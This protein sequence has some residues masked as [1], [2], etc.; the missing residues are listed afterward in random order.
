IPSAASISNNCSDDIQ[1]LISEWEAEDLKESDKL[2]NEL[3]SAQLG[4]QIKPNR[5]CEHGGP[6]CCPNKDKGDKSPWE[7]VAPEIA[8][9]KLYAVW[10]EIYARR[11]TRLDKLINRCK[12]NDTEKQYY[13]KMHEYEDA[14]SQGDFVSA[15]NKLTEASRYV[16]DNVRNSY[17]SE[18]S[19]YNQRVEQHRKEEEAEKKEKEEYEKR[20][21]EEAEKKEKEESEKR[22]KEEKEKNQKKDSTKK[23]K[24]SG[25]TYVIPSTAE[26][27]RERAKYNNIQE[28][29]TT[30]ALRKKT[31]M[32]M[33]LANNAN[34]EPGFYEDY[35]VAYEC[36]PVICFNILPMYTNTTFG[37]LVTNS[38]YGEYSSISCAF[39]MG[40]GANLILW[41]VRG[42][43]FG[44][45]GL[46]NYSYGS[47]FI[48]GSSGHASNFLYGTRIMGGL[49]KYKVVFDLGKGSRSG[50]YNLDLDASL[51]SSG[52]LIDPTNNYTS[53]KFDYSL[54]KSGYG[55]MYESY[56]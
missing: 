25:S 16:T 10:N 8:L 34:R 55:L 48:S 32:V 17:N 19:N 5:D 27:A 24:S 47:N 45:G 22:K 23:S 13:Q 52:Y 1:N 40:L 14:M 53:G 29:K 7:K 6:E 43:Y 35:C 54:K 3:C 30:D 31:D 36:T 12:E 41:P 18:K 46:C 39:G 11:K 2:R 42:P 4:W 15:K 49:K 21:K 51:A 50:S 44:L 9:R 33:S 56:D 28:K 37:G 26:L 38:T 20:K